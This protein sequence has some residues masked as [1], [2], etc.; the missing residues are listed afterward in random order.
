MLS[1][2]SRLPQLYTFAENISSYISYRLHYVHV[3]TTSFILHAAYMR[4]YI[5]TIK[6][7]LSA[8]LPVESDFVIASVRSEAR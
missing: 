6:K 5:P 7:K 3:S 1:A 4:M 8:F 2:W